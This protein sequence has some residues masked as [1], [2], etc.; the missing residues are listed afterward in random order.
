VRELNRDERR[1]FEE[2]REKKKSIGASS[3]SNKE[4][5]KELTTLLK[6]LVEDFISSLIGEQLSCTK[7][8]LPGGEE[9]QWD[10]NEE[11][12][13]NFDALVFGHF[14]TAGQNL[15][16]NLLAARRNL[17]KDGLRATVWNLLWHYGVNL[18]NFVVTNIV[19]WAA[20]HDHGDIILSGIPP[21]VISFINE[22]MKAKLRCLGEPKKVAGF[23]AHVRTF[24]DNEG[25][26]NA[27]EPW[28]FHFD[29]LHL[30]LFTTSAPR[31]LA[32]EDYEAFGA[33]VDFLDG[34]E[35]AGEDLRRAREGGDGAE[36]TR[37]MIR[38]R[39]S[40]A[41]QASWR[42]HQAAGTQHPVQIV[43]RNHQA[44]GTQHPTQIGL[45]ES[46][47]NYQAA[48]TRHPSQIANAKKA[49][50]RGTVQIPPGFVCDECGKSFEHEVSFT[51][52]KRLGNFRSSCPFC[53]TQKG[54]YSFAK[55]TSIQKFFDGDGGRACFT[56]SD[57]QKA[58][59]DIILR[60][61]KSIAAL[62]KCAKRAENAME[63]YFSHR[64]ITSFFSPAPPAPSLPPPPSPAHISTLVPMEFT[65]ICI[66]GD[67]NCQFRAI[68]DQMFGNQ[69]NHGQVRQAVISE[70]EN[71]RG[72]Y[73]TELQALRVADQAAYEM[74]NGGW[75]HAGMDQ[76]EMWNAYIAELRNGPV[77]NTWFG[78]GDDIT[79]RAA[80]NH[81][82]VQIQVYGGS[83]IL[84]EN[85]NG[86]TETTL[87]LFLE[88]CHYTSLR[89][90][91]EE[92]EDDDEN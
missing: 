73:M 71:N 16:G 88:D 10:E 25:Y 58:F 14:E 80:A 77:P 50:D 39:Q 87:N 82:R 27:Q 38:A 84:V 11:Q 86:T 62:S 26:T 37:E 91:T 75:S 85:L 30:S 32:N 61:I 67:G 64:T 49:K 45:R 55:L 52:D 56:T 7:T 81:Y 63:E 22:L 92:E 9:G 53:R 8:A 48:G 34:R 47:R 12:L 15:G 20:P 13:R 4:K 59:A 74:G 78:W 31:V 33:L 24:A 40:E 29:S 60:K 90:R 89:R 21:D 2:L 43:W 70:M 79:L 6:N 41:M 23:G 46:W 18:F 44:A 72:R 54:S 83:G 35:G 51:I 5:Y 3:L 36:T 68:A 28:M 57:K 1:L 69:D 19:P 66:A 42:T 17:E 65:S 76:E